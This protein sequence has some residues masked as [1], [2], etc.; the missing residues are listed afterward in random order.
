M[1]A[2]AISSLTCVSD[3]PRGLNESKIACPWG[4]MVRDSRISRSP[5]KRLRASLF[6][7]FS[8]SAPKSDTP[9]NAP[10]PMAI[11]TKK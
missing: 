1:A 7:V 9:V 2:I 10:T 4:L 3:I 5:P 11:Q 8:T 6:T